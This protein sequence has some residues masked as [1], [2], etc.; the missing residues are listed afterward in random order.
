MYMQH[1]L[2]T[3]QEDLCASVSG[4]LHKWQLYS[5]QHLHMQPWLLPGSQWQVQAVVATL[6]PNL[7]QEIARENYNEIDLRSIIRP[8]KL[9]LRGKEL[10]AHMFDELGGWI[11]RHMGDSKT[12]LARAFKFVR[13]HFVRDVIMA[14]SLQNAAIAAVFFLPGADMPLLTLNQAKMFLKIAAAY[15]AELDNERLK[16]LAVL[17]ASGFGLRA[18]SR[19]LVGLVPMFG[20]AMR[21]S[22]GYGGTYALGNA[23]KVY[24]E[25]EGD[26]AKIAENL[27]TDAQQVVKKRGRLQN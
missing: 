2:H 26:F 23:A 19:K 24:F 20:W 25:G 4:W 5:T 27:K 8:L 21:G 7:V 11:V 6:R 15:G 16:E 22:V 14:T 18:V 9:T 3:T 10:Y 12:S 13:E 1:W 17:L